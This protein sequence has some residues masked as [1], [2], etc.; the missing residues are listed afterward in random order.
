MTESYTRR[1]TWGVMFAVALVM[2]AVS[3]VSA[4]DH[5]FT[6]EDLRELHQTI[7]NTRAGIAAE[8]EVDAAGEI[9]LMERI[10]KGKR[11]KGKG[12]KGKGGKRSKSSKKS[13][14]KSSSS[15][16]DEE[17][18]PAPTPESERTDAPVFPWTHFISPT[19]RAHSRAYG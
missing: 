7:E 5:E 16:E 15:S 19:N 10:L 2:L 11:G 1:R 18:S 17:E 14:K 3:G 6:T 12:G 9:L 8:A 4:N 13:S